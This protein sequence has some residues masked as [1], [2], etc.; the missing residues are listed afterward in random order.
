[1][2]KI[3]ELPIKKLPSGRWQ[4]NVPAALSPE[5][6]R[7]R[8]TFETKKLAELRREAILQ[9][10]KT[11]G[12]KAVRVEPTLA[13]DA[14]RAANLLKGHEI[15]LTALAQDFLERLQAREASQTFD[16]AWQ[17]ATGEKGTVSEAYAHT[18]DVTYQKVKRSLGN[19]LLCEIDH[20]TVRRVLEKYFPTAH[21]FNTARAVLSPVFRVGVRERWMMENPI[22]RIPPRKIPSREIEI[23]T[24]D[25]AKEV[26][27]ACADHRKNE[28]L[29]KVFRLDCRNTAPA[30]A[31]MLFAGIRP[32]E[33]ARMDWKDIHFDTGE[34]F[35]QGRNSKTRTTRYAAMEANLVAWLSTIPKKER[36]GSIV[37][38]QWLKKYKAV[39]IVAGIN[40][41]QQD[42]L[43]HSFGSYHLKMYDDLN[44]TRSAMGHTGTD[45]LFKHYRAVARKGDAIQF[46]SLYPKGIEPVLKAVSGGSL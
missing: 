13:A 35:V 14:I 27:A 19:K 11:Y 44:A 41:R 7:T 15:T 24:P 9:D 34:V 18:L 46:F 39:R 6:R 29:H 2:A 45:V 32:A 12:A 3:S 8:P 1:M 31:L 21:Y 30:I 26:M 25:E 43:R 20:E 33:V 5:G 36:K 10:A 17:V 37:P 16:H 22:S 4:M 23:L 28:D 42:I 38:A 40:K